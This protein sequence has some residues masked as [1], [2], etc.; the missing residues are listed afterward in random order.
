METFAEFFKYGEPA[1][2][3][4]ELEVEMPIG[5]LAI[6]VTAVIFISLNFHSSYVH[7]I[8]NRSSALLFYIETT[9]SNTR[10]TCFT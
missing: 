1:M 10:M 8:L 7:L 2:K 4:P 5:A 6:A 3:L 9:I